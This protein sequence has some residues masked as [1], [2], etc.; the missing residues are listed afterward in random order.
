MTI[1]SETRKAGPYTGNGVTTSFTF[2]FKVFTAADVYVVTANASGTETTLVL[3]TDYT[4]TLNSNQDSNPGGT[5]TLSSALAS[6]NTLTITSIITPLQATDLTNQG[7]FYPSVITNALDKLTILIQQITGKISRAISVPLSDTA[8]SLSL[9]SAATRANQIVGFDS[10]GNV[11]T[12]APVTGVMN[13]SPTTITA[14]AGQTLFT[15]GVTYT[16]GASSLAVYRNGLLQTVGTDYQETSSTKVTILTAADVGEVFTF[17]SSPGINTQSTDSSAVAFGQ[18]GTGAISRT[19]KSKLQEFVS[20]KDFGAAGDGAIVGGVVTGTNDTAAIA[21]AIAACGTSK[22]LYFPDGTYVITPNTL[23][24]ITCSVYGPSATAIASSW[25]SG[26]GY[27]FKLNYNETYP[28]TL[29]SGVTGLNAWKTFSFNE[30]IGSPDNSQQNIGIYCAGLDESNIDVRV[31]RGCIQ[32][33]WMDGYTNGVHMGTN[34]INVTHMYQC[35]IGLLMQSSSIAGGFL[36]ANRI[37]GTYWYGFSTAAISTAGSGTQRVC[38]NIFNILSLGVGIANGHAIWLGSNSLRN[39]FQIRSWD[40]GVSGTGKYIIAPSGTADNIFQVPAF[41]LSSVTWAGNNILDSQT[42]LADGN[43]RSVFV[44]TSAPA[45][46]TWRAGDTCWNNAPIS[47]GTP[48]WICTTGGTP[49]TWR[50]ID[51]LAGAPKFRASL[52]VTQSVSINTDTTAIFN[53]VLFDTTTAY[54][55]SNGVYTPAVAGYYKVT[56]SLKI[57]GTSLSMASLMLRKNGGSY[58]E[59]QTIPT[60]LGTGTVVNGSSLVYLNGSTDNI[61]LT[62]YVQAASGAGFSTGAFS[63]TLIQTA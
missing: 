46:G 21:A 52:T 26:Q 18:S 47:G 14:T 17:V 48:G 4:L 53:S 13:I 16:P 29:G 36:E 5:I 7:G 59:L 28:V 20:V 25:T 57:I 10:S 30:I 39:T 19:V 2:A 49:G 51:A 35:G 23:P 40:A 22:T 38:D 31:I 56:A 54:N 24:A 44:G 15:L 32:G 43:G 42:S 61:S 55:S 60:T 9:P 45:S 50:A 27:I 8:T 34:T 1:S 33:I 3:N 12:Y 63:A 62:G 37:T 11:V 58:E 41:S 6:T